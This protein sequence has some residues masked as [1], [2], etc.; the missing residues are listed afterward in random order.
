MKISLV[1]VSAD[2]TLKDLPPMSL[3]IPIGRGEECKVRIPLAAV[4]RKHCELLEDDDELIVRDLKSSNGT[5]VNKERVRQ[6]ELLPGDLL[7]VGPVLLVVRIDGHPKVIDPIIAWANG[8]VGGAAGPGESA[9][10]HGDAGVPTWNSQQG[11][12]PAA[13]ATGSKS[14]V[15]APA[16]SRSPAPKAK[17]SDIDSSLDEIIKDLSESDFD[18][19]FD[20][21]KKK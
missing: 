10:D 16:S 21:P 14:P 12:K 8:A 7:A 18:I 5:Y 2:G 13:P 1:M 15:P 4:S 9:G 17:G 20:K 11:Q 19:D 3:P 6:R